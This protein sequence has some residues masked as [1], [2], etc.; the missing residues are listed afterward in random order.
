[1]QRKLAFAVIV[2][3]LALLG[4]IARIFL[5][6]NK[7]FDSYNQK[8]LSQQRYDSREIPY[9]RG[10][11]TD[12]NGTYIAISKK[13]YNVILDPSQ[14]LAK[15][16]DY[17]EPTVDLLVEVFGYNKEEITKL[18]DEK[19]DSSYVRYAKNISLEKRNEFNEK[20]KEYNKNSLNQR[21]SKRI[22]GVWFEESYQ[23]EYPYN[24]L[25]STV[26]GFGSSDGSGGTGGIE[27]Y[28][29]S[30]LVGTSG[31]EYGY[32]NEE[33]SLE[34]IIKPAVDGNT[35]VSTIDLKIQSIAEKYIDE[36]EKEARSKITAV[37][38]MNPKNG[39]ILALATSRKYDPNDPKNLS[40]YYLEE[41]IAAMD[42]EAKNTA[43]NTV[44]RNYVVSDTYEPGSP[45]K[46]FTVASA[47][48]EG[49][50]QTEDSFA[51][52]GGQQI[53]D[54]FIRCVARTGHGQL[55]VAEALMVSCN[56]TMM[57]I[58]ARLGK[59]RFSKYMDLFGFG[60]KTGIDL[61]GEADTSTLIH[62]REKMGATDL[63]TNAFGQNYNTTMIQTAAAMSS[64]IN[65]GYYYKP[66]IV[67]QILNSNGQV[68]ENIEPELVKE[69]VSDNTSKFIN[70]ALRRTVA[71]GTGAAAK[72]EG[73]NIG[74]KTGTAEKYPR[75][76]GNYLVSF[77]GFAPTDNPQVLCYVLID[78]PGVADQAHSTFASTIFSKIMTEVLPYMNIFPE[79]DVSLEEDVV[80]GINQGIE[81]ST[82]ESTAETESKVYPTDEVVPNDGENGYEGENSQT[83]APA[84]G[85]SAGKET[86]ANKETKSN[87]ETQASKE[88]KSNKETQASKETKANKETKKN[89]KTKKQGGQ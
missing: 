74:G 40:Y 48:E 50:I 43:W 44:W 26:I 22:H 66:H 32:I 5:I 14:M 51:C 29:N 2:I 13:V 55:T 86:K 46:V 62:T 45:S 17:M 83:S 49:A 87:K 60:K 85:E 78:Q 81:E 71:Q 31:R 19:A 59:D 6:Q 10:D 35:V 79:T 15:K 1:M 39:E 42:E 47:L 89:E 33:S 12:R 77:I 3:M 37:L 20:L 67:K 41:E 36:W 56:D 30:T 54:R 16:E 80:E 58:S 82:A 8:I 7:N 65:G 76:Q 70:E 69:T 72:V 21:S 11:I 52:D 28:Y 57:Q 18:I 64:V 4:L 68:V 63:A 9:K 75:G 84:E 27:Q 38:I 34:R 25:A 61:P 23:R 24:T 53:G 73:Y 88:T